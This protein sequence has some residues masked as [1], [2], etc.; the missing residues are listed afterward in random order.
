MPKRTIRQTY[1][2]LFGG[3]NVKATDVL[4]SQTL[5]RPLE[6]QDLLNVEFDR[7]GG[8]AKRKGKRPRADNIGNALFASDTFGSSSV[9]VNVAAGSSN[10]VGICQKITAPSSSNISGALV[11]LSLG[12]FTAQF[13]VKNIKMT[14]RS[15]NAG[16]PGSIITNGTSTA[17]SDA[18]GVSTSLTPGVGTHFFNFTNPPAV[19]SGVDYWFCIEADLD[20]TDAQFAQQL[21]TSLETASGTLKTTNDNYSTFTSFTGHYFYEI[22]T[23]AA[24]IMGL[25]DYKFSDASGSFSQKVMAVSTNASSG[26]A[27]LW[28]ADGPITDTTP[29]WTKIYDFAGVTHKNNLSD[30]ATANNYLFVS[31]NNHVT[32]I[33]VEEMRV[34]DGTSSSTMKHGYRA[35]ATIGFTGGGGSWTA[36]G[37]HD[38]L[39]VTALKSGGYRARLYPIIIAATDTINLT[40]VKV[41]AVADQ[42]LFDIDTDA[43]TIFIKTPGLDR[44]HKLT[45]SQ[46]AN[47][48]SATPQ[49]PILNSETA[50]DIIG[51]ADSV[52]DTQETLLDIYGKDDDYFTL[53]VDAPRVKYNETG[54]GFLFMAG[55]PLNPS[56]LWISALNQPNI[57]SEAGGVDGSFIE[58]GAENDGEK[59]VGIKHAFGALF[60]FKDTQVWR[61]KFT[62][63]ASFPFVGERLQ[64]SRISTLS[65][66]AIVETERG[67]V[68]PSQ[69]GMAICDGNS[70]KV[71]AEEKIGPLFEKTSGSR[72]ELNQLKYSTGVNYTN[73]KQAWFTISTLG[74]DVRDKILV[75]DYNLN[76]WS[77]YNGI[78][79]NY[80]GIV[81]D[82]DNLP[83][84]WSGDLAGQLYK[85]DEGDHDGTVG[86]VGK[87]AIDFF[88]NSPNFI[89]SD[90]DGEKRLR[91][92]TLK[93]DVNST[94]SFL[95]MDVFTNYGN[96]VE[97][98]HAFTTNASNFGVDSYFAINKKGKAI[99]LRFRNSGADQPM[100]LQ[101]ITLHYQRLG[102]RK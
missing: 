39:F 73:K 40:S 51:A 23:D 11:A 47:F 68:F 4:V 3:L 48:A 96:T 29:T 53:Q 98:T 102:A 90:T 100:Q 6:S 79:A 43:T 55:D 27:G 80:L 59:I 69:A 87:S 30:F 31:S 49:N 94:I 32:D 12:L 66:F 42:F 82:A 28:Y 14:I 38:V 9:T 78:N 84:I 35:T 8:L 65:H 64:G 13:F 57:I 19:T 88:W 74:G 36:A 95:Y 86:D 21:F 37:A 85:C 24:P 34:W 20:A 25:Y 16:D 61:Y 45:A 60:V 46:M 89:F 10:T 52:L 62:G 5:S 15:D 1:P 91:W 101:T 77:I 99:R 72:I 76:V 50:F 33:P 58:V 26:V 54:D 81:T 97:Q 75:W 71:L 93:G 41:D 56:R 44:F 70:V 63:D 18:T 2:L 83:E 22:Y 7:L 17:Y 67:I 92:V